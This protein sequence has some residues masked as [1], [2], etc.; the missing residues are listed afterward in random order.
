M[1][2]G[3]C[4]FN[5]KGKDYFITVFVHLF[6]LTA[7]SFG[8]YGPWAAARLW[9]LKASHT[10]IRGKQVLFVGKGGDLFLRCLLWAFLCLVTLGIYSP[11]AACA[12]LRWK[13][14]NTLVGG[15]PSR[16]TGNGGNLL[17]LSLLHLFIF[18]IMTLGIYLFWGLYRMYAW[19]E[20]NTRYGDEKTSFG[21]GVG[22]FIKISIISW[23]LNLVTFNIFSPWAMC[24]LYGWQIR[25]L[26]VGEGEAVAHFNPVRT[27][28]I[29]LILPPLIAV[30]LVYLVLTFLSGFVVR[31]VGEGAQTA[32]R[33]SEGMK[34][35]IPL[36]EKRPDQPKSQ[37]SV[38]EAGPRRI[39]GVFAP[40]KPREAEEAKGAS[41]DVRFSRIEALLQRE[42]GNAV[43]YYSRGWVH[44]SRGELDKALADYNQALKIAPA[45]ADAYF[46]RG[47]VYVQTGKYDLAAEDF[48][49][50]LRYE[51]ESSDAFSNRGS[52]YLQ[53]GKIDQA[54]MDFTDAI[55]LAPDDADVVYNR[56]VAF[57]EKGD[58]QK[59]KLDLIRAETLG[60]KGA[61]E[62]HKSLQ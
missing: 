22:E 18:P 21:A 3:N 9:K 7:L 44:Q 31:M 36:G 6:L 4:E 41:L 54:I 10:V 1:P 26:M 17:A 24:M 58:A 49:A 19:K 28:R 62:L 16:F 40:P 34:V 57:L 2:K 61:S 48:S 5:G 59:A 8:I 46:N 11:W 20:E 50:V 29:L 35:R 14:E 15:R 27:P 37:P 60:H 39:I 45:F 33:S 32:S 55:R 47:V 23:I 53:Q 30:L 52:V 42:P 13:A 43:A 56:A 25:G 38:K 12:F 51:K